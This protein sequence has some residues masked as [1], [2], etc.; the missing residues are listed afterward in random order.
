MILKSLYNESGKNLDHHCMQRYVL[1]GPGT[2][3]RNLTNDNVL[4]KFM[5]V[6]NQT[7]KKKKE[8][9]LWC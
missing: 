5:I 9:S 3:W 1:D 4:Y 8:G 6:K 7:K 2:T